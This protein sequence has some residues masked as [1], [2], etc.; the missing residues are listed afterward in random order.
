M[1]VSAMTVS[2]DR[3]RNAWIARYEDE[4]AGIE[5]N[6][7]KDAKERYERNLKA[8]SVHDTEWAKGMIRSLERTISHKRTMI[9]KLSAMN[10]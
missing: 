8:G 1:R 6:A 7:L 5:R 10:F 3:E 2:N 4:I 9:A